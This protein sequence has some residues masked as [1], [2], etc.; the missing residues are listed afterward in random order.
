MRKNILTAVG[1]LLVVLSFFGAKTI[2]ANKKKKKPKAEKVTQSV[3]VTPVNNKNIPIVISST[4]SVKAKRRV[5][6]YAE[7]QGVFKGGSNSFKTG[8]AF[9]KGSQLI[10]IDSSEY[11]STVQSAKSEFYNLPVSYTH[12]TLPTIYSV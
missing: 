11:Y 10:R 9:K 2:I 5:E 8:Q 6:L 1:L 3:Y 7:V 4:G 12:L